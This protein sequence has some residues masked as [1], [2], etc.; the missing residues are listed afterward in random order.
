M[1]EGP[2]ISQA[3]VAVKPD[4]TPDGLALRV[5]EQEHIIY[6]RALRLI[7][8]GRIRVSGERV[9]IDGH[10]TPDGHLTNPE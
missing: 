3:V 1:D 5:L 7:A 8:E 2:I 10:K 4:D 6:P 9:I